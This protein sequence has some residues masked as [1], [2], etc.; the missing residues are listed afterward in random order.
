VILILGQNI[1]FRVGT[2]FS[3]NLETACI[4]PAGAGARRGGDRR[5]RVD[6]RPRPRQ[7]RGRCGTLHRRASRGRPL[8][9]ILNPAGQDSRVRYEMRV[10]VSPRPSAAP[11]WTCTQDPDGTLSFTTPHGRVYR[12]R[13]PTATRQRSTRRDRPGEPGR[14]I[15][16]L[17]PILKCRALSRRV[18][19]ARSAPGS[20]GWR[21]PT[22]QRGPAGVP[23][24]A[25]RP[26]GGPRSRGRAGR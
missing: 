9:L 11:G 6:R 5:V 25:G 24:R 17:I 4:R 15:P 23:G 26:G 21:G 7:P 18:P 12:T 22:G 16:V 14:G 1:E 10:V 20:A 19:R 3:A 2:V 13:P 8:D